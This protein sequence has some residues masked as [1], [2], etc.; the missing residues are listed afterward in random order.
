M[1]LF[2]TT[3]SADVIY[4]SVDTKEK[5]KAGNVAYAYGVT[6]EMCKADYWAAKT[7]TD[8]NEVLMQKRY[9]Q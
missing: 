3:V 5:S 6:E 7:K 9:M 2:A 4:K 1:A 8:A